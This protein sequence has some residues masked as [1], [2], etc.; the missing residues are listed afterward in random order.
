MSTIIKSLLTLLLAFSIF[1]ISSTEYLEQ[2]TPTAMEEIVEKDLVEKENSDETLLL[3]GKIIF[4]HM[5]QNRVILFF[6]NFTHF[7]YILKPFRP[8]IFS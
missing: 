5:L 8:P 4:T 6:Q 3:S 7:I 1:L 2:S